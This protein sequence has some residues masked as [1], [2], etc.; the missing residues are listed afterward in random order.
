VR[1]V[2]VLQVITDDDWRGAQVFM[3]DLHSALEARGRHVRTVAL[4]PGTLGSRLSVPVL[5]KTRLGAHTLR[6]LRGEMR[7]AALTIAGGSTTL[8]ACAIAGAGLRCRNVYRQISDNRFWAPSR[9]RRLRVRALMSRYDRVVAMYG[10]AAETLERYFHVP[11]SR[12]AVIPNAST[13]ARYPLATAAERSAARVRFGLDPQRHVIAYVGALV[14][15]KGVDVAIHALA[16]LPDCQLLIAGAGPAQ[17]ELENLAEM[18]VPG[19]SVF[20]G[21]VSRPAD[22]Y[23]A[24]DV[25]VLPSRGG[26]SMPT[27]LME[28]GFTGRAAVAT[29]IEGIP[30]IV[31]DGRTGRIVAVDDPRALARGIQDVLG[32]AVEFGYEARRWCLERFEIN[33]VADA[34]RDLIDELVDVG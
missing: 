23:A 13:A 28:A 26:D 19:R 24:S 12:L 2:D 21:P 27:A 11:W 3:V 18:T 4:A 25:V 1:A 30:E 6:A 33:P 7:Q 22:V 9:W 17:S 16:H 29:P 31:V 34:W 20:V 8:A 15:E 32:R 5:G 14:P 10:G